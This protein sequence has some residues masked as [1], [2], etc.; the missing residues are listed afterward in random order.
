MSFPDMLVYI[1]EKSN[2]LFHIKAKEIPLHLHKRAQQSRDAIRARLRDYCESRMYARFG[3]YTEERM[4]GTEIDEDLFALRNA[5][6]FRVNREGTTADLYA[7]V[8]RRTG[9][10]EGTF[11]VWSFIHRKNGTD[12]PKDI[13]PNAPDVPLTRFAKS[14][15]SITRVFVEDSTEPPENF[16][17]DI[18][19]LV[20]LCHYEPLAET[21]RLTYVGCHVIYFGDR[22]ERIAEMARSAAGIPPNSK[23]AMFDLVRTSRVDILPLHKTVEDLKLRTGDVIAIQAVPSDAEAEGMRYPCIEGWFE[24]LDDRTTVSFRELS[25][26]DTETARVQMLKKNTYSEV[27]AALAK[28]LSNGGSSSS[29]DGKNIRLTGCKDYGNGPRKMP[30][31]LSENVT[32]KTMLEHTVQGGQIRLS[33]V[34]Y[35]EV[36]QRTLAEVENERVV[37]V[38]W[39]P[40]DMHGAEKITLRVARAGKI[41]SILEQVAAAHPSQ[42]GGAGKYRL[43]EVYRGKVYKE[44]SADAPL[45]GIPETRSQNTVYRVE[46]KTLREDKMG[47]NDVRIQVVHLANESSETF[48]GSP[49]YLVVG[50][51]AKLGA[52]KEEVQKRLGA[53]DEDFA[54]CKFAFIT[55]TSHKPATNDDDAIGDLVGTFEY[56]GIVHQDKKSAAALAGS[57]SGKKQ[58]HDVVAIKIKN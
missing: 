5:T 44:Y 47:E 36:L 33:G 22:M 19:G 3:A 32:L 25:H 21:G 12:R 6:E 39:M 26:T 58:S 18:N 42:P 24:Y 45:S 51:E 28:A 49:F 54:K 48:F 52:V 2:M 56:F 31:T 46:E 7:E 14:D 27:T 15:V 41:A 38:V 34:L 53:S 35:Y 50:K 9:R 13:I 40:M 30:F 20:F 10:R 8:A 29:V 17:K 16:H 37:D 57:I 4:S 55:S 11:R 43:L 23:I 1:R